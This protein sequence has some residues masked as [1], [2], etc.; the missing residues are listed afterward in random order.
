M[1]SLLTLY[2]VM[3]WKFGDDISNGSGVIVLTDKRSDE[4]RHKQT[5]LKTI[6]PHYATLITRPIVSATTRFSIT[7]EIRHMI[8]GWDRI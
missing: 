1:A 6:P 2:R 4:Q 3:H 5:L 8:H 7:R